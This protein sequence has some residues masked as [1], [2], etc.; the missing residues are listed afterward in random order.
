MK[1]F[2]NILLISLFAILL[3]GSTVTGLTQAVLYATNGTANVPI[4]IDKSTRAITSIDYAHHEIHSGVHYHVSYCDNDV[5]SGQTAEL[6]IV[7]PNTTKWAHLKFTVTFILVTSVAVFEDT[8]TSA[9]G[10]GLTEWNSNRNA[11][12]PV[13]TSVVTHTPTVTVTGNAIYNSYGGISTGLFTREGGESRN[14]NEFILKQNTKYLFNA[15]SLTND[16]I[17]CWQL[18]WYEHTDKN[19]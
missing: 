16:N 15:T 10:T 8:T 19:P 11:G 18:D 14:D 5:D 2:K 4:Q 9:D 7:T 17:I 6:L 13:A 3:L 1:N 12:F